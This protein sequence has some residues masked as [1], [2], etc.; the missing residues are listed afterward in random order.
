[1]DLETIFWLV[2]G[3]LY[4]LIQFGGKKKKSPA[5]VPSPD[6]D[7]GTDPLSRALEEIRQSLAPPAPEPPPTRLPASPQPRAT[8]LSK[9]R[10]VLPDPVLPPATPVKAATKEAPLPPLEPGAIRE[11][12]RTRKSLRE[13]FVLAEVL[14]PPKSLRR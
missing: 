8:S 5:P 13:A 4:L 1:M 6:S 12:L 7:A 3:A 14:G 2:V 11:R 9:D 10:E